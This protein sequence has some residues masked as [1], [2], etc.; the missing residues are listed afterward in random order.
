MSDR[1]KLQIA[2]PVGETATELAETHAIGAAIRRAL[3]LEFEYSLYA[4]PGFT[5][6]LLDHL[7]RAK[8]KALGVAEE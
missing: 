5:Q 6:R 3:N 4:A 8:K 1:T 2:I 7:H